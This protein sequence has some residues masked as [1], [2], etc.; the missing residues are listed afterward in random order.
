MRK[1]RIIGV[2][3]CADA[4]KTTLARRVAKLVNGSVVDGDDYLHDKQGVFLMAWRLDYLREA[5]DAALS[6]NPPVFISSVCLLDILP[7]IDVKADLMVYVERRTPS[8]LPGDLDILDC[9]KGDDSHLAEFSELN[10]EICRYHRDFKPRARAD[11]IFLRQ[12]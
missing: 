4:G 11:V 8:D 2:D 10:R 9:E 6:S 12:E 7:R 5:I 1:S 3:G